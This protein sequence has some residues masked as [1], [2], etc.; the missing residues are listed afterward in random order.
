MANKQLRPGRQ[1]LILANREPGDTDEEAYEKALAKLES[2]PV[3]EFSGARLHQ[4]APR[5]YALAVRLIAEGLPVSRIARALGVSHHTIE[6]IRKRECVSVEAE[7]SRLIELTKSASRLCIERLIEMIP[8]MSPRD[9]SVAY[10]I[11]VEKSLLLSGDP[12][13]ISATKN[14]QLSHQSFNQLLESLP[15]ANVI[16]VGSSQQAPVLEPKVEDRNEQ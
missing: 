9:V 10:G 5:T 6:A 7:R 13:F 2:G 8:E 16:E 14:E 11:T 4:Q 12:V 3:K 15:Q 1:S